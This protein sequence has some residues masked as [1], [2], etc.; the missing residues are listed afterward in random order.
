MNATF[1]TSASNISAAHPGSC[2]LI[3]RAVL[4]RLY[5]RLLADRLIYICLAVRDEKGITENVQYRCTTFV[6]K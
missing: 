3:E 6:Q 4:L 1:T 2:P 5:T